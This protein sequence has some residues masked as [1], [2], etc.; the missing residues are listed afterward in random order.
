MVDPDWVN[1]YDLLEKN[2]NINL[3]S[4]SNLTVDYYF[5]SLSGLKYFP[6]PKAFNRQGHLPECYGWIRGLIF[7][8]WL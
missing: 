8:A 6:F 4:F 2:V 7:G 3:A 1:E 5:Y